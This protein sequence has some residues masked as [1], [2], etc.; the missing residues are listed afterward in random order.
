MYPE[1]ENVNTMRLEF[2]V[3]DLV[4]SI[5]FYERVLGFTKTSGETGGYTVMQLGEA[6][7]DL[8]PVDVLPLEHPVNPLGTERVGLG[9][10]IVLDVDDVQRM[11]ER[12]QSSGWQLSA[13]LKARPWGG[14][15]FRVQDPDGRYIRVTSRS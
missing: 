6:R 13:P 10:E 3:K 2:F 1:E 11:Y 5:D 9:I 7:I 4:R 15:D 14:T 12:A 8:Q